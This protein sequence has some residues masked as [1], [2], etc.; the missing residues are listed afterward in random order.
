[1]FHQQKVGV[2]IQVGPDKEKYINANWSH[3]WSK[4][5]IIL[6]QKVSLYAKLFH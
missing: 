4:F 3:W 2:G 6:Q 5:F 1:M